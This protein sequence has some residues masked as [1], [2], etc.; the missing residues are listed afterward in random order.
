MKPYYRCVATRTRSNTLCGPGPIRQIR[1]LRLAP[2]R[3]EPA[4]IRHEIFECPISQGS[5]E[6]LSY[7]WGS[8]D[9]PQPIQVSEWSQYGEDDVGGVSSRRNSRKL[10]FVANLLESL[11]HPPRSCANHSL[12]IGTLCINQDD[13]HERRQQVAQMGQIYASIDRV[14]V[15]LGEDYSDGSDGA[16]KELKIAQ[17]WESGY[18]RRADH[19]HHTGL[20]P[21]SRHSWFRR[22][23]LLQEVAI[24]PQ[25][26]GETS[27]L[28]DSATLHLLMKD[29]F[30]R[31]QQTRNGTGDETN[32]PFALQL[33]PL[34]DLMHIFVTG[35]ATRA[36]DSIYA[37]LGIA[38]DPPDDS[39]LTPVHR[40]LFDAHS[41][42]LLERPGQCEVVYSV[43]YTSAS[44]W[45]EMLERWAA[46]YLA[47]FWI[48]ECSGPGSQSLRE[49]NE[50][51]RGGI[52]QVE[53]QLPGKGR[54][55]EAIRLGASAG[56][57]LMIR[58]G[59]LGARPNLF[60][61]GAGEGACD[62]VLLLEFR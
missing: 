19:R 5:Y 55:A 6:A 45:S 17:G 47:T 54:S 37:L 3:D 49:G 27:H 7:T 44:G 20:N 8:P 42:N 12:W 13:V 56:L 26:I 51:H 28:G 61:Y 58:R 2:H 31:S 60:H 43:E 35:F 24:S 52:E 57:A 62:D 46:N 50:T 9:N 25:V 4:P 1:L 16:S 59:G 29:T 10:S 34:V 53:S 33:A 22:K 15:W 36:E 40:T 39:D 48:T 18:D 21:L 14:H 38:S 11:T 41:L 30:D 23:W 32:S